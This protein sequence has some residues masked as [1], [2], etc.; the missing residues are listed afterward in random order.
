MQ[1]M[2]SEAAAD[3]S[4]CEALRNARDLFL[5]RQHSHQLRK[6]RGPRVP[7]RHY[8]DSRRFGGS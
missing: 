4:Q 3:C 5:P 6:I 8:I 1:M 2:R 7:Q